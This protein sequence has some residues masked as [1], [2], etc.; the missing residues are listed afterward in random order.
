MGKQKGLYLASSLSQTP[1]VA[2]T[3][4]QAD[5]A[6]Q[7]VSRIYLRPM[8]AQESPSTA[9]TSMTAEVARITTRVIRTTAKEVA[10]FVGIGLLVKTVIPPLVSLSTKL[11]R[12]H[13]EEPI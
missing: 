3:K 10:A 1:A 6:G 11:G 2:A 4:S 5:Q 8:A 13:V 12:Y 7:K 9:A